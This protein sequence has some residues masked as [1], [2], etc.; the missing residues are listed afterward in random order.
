[1]ISLGA[2]VQSTAMALMAAHGEITPMPDCA[3][4]ADTGDEPQRVYDHL[5]WL[6]SGNV[7]PF[8]V[9]IVRAAGRLGEEIIKATRGESLRG[10]H[11]R[12]PFYVKGIYP[13]GSTVPVLD[14]DGN[15]VGE[16]VRDTI[17]KKVRELIN[18]RP[19]QQWPKEVRVHQWIGISTD[20]AVRMKPSRIPAIQA[21][22]PLIERR[23][24]R[25]DCKLWLQRNGY[26]EPPKSACTFCPYRS[27]DQ[28]RWLRDTD[29]VAWQ[30]AIEVDRA[31]RP[32]LRSDAL[33]GELY[34]HR[35]MIPLEEVDLSTASERGQPDLFGDEC[36]G[37][38]GV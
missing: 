7:L 31:I 13:A 26:P 28:W 1:M 29:P 17:Q 23:L 5:A 6:M 32:G 14:D 9:H 37:M 3:I 12:P 11:A 19:R 22:W 30:Y 18:L 4:F 21:R 15:Q 10:S 34:V 36:E 33:Q 8:P 20:E 25:S 16:R 2:G 35:S 24:S 27:D 38:C